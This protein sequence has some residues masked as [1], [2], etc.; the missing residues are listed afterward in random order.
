MKSEKKFQLHQKDTLIC[1]LSDM[2]KN[3]KACLDSK[4][5]QNFLENVA[6]KHQAI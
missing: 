4:G 3:R 2:K 1:I 5:E 6:N